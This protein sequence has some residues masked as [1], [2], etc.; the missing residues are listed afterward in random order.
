MTVKLP[1]SMPAEKAYSQEL[2]RSGKWH[3]LWRVADS[4]SNVGIFDVKDNAELQELVS[5]LPFFPYMET[6]VKPLCSNSSSIR[7]DDS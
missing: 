3:H 7:E 1:L 2:Q 5:N 6:S 4:Y